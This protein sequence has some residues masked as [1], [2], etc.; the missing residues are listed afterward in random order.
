MDPI[1]IKKYIEE[2]LK[3]NLPS[4]IFLDK[5]RV[6]EEVSRKSFAYNDSGYIPLYYW[7][8]TIF[9]AK[10][11]VEIGFR[12]GLLS[13][14]FL[15]SCKT[16]NCFLALQEVR[17]GEY[18]SNRLGKANIKDSYKG[19]FN[20]H[21]GSANDEVFVTKLKALDIDLVIINILV[22]YG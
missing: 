15:K 16:V 5:M 8:G 14:N 20:I 12:L 11:L 2:K 9:P 17:T 19:Y 7:L 3:K 10:T 22:L 13:G 18:Y 21:V 6:I 4:H 1:E